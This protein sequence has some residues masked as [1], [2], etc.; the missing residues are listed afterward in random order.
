M[1]HGWLIRIRSRR[2]YWCFG[3]MHLEVTRILSIASTPKIQMIDTKGAVDPGSQRYRR[4][5]DRLGEVEPFFDLVPERDDAR[6]IVR[7][8]PIVVTARA[9]RADQC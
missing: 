2:G 3:D 1:F 5:S 7:S 9:A 4:L 6:S 8:R